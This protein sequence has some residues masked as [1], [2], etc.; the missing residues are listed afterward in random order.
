MNA[1]YVTSIVLAAGDT[2][3]NTT[4][5]APTLRELTSYSLNMLS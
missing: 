2:A 3:V 5:K 1:Y 4:E